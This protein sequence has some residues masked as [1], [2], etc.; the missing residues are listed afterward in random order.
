MCMCMW[1]LLLVCLP[2]GEVLQRSGAVIDAR[3]RPLSLAARSV[4][5][6]EAAADSSANS[7][8]VWFTG[9]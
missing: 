5:A 6:E 1:A 3:S 7:I 9:P 2:S 4:K 8:G